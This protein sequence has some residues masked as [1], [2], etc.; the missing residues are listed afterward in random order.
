MK[1]HKYHPNQVQSI[2]ILYDNNKEWTVKNPTKHNL[3]GFSQGLLQGTELPT[4]LW[5][6]KPSVEEFAT[7]HYSVL[8]QDMAAMEV[9][10]RSGAVAFIP[11]KP[12]AHFVHGM[13]VQ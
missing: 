10:H 11:L 3:A 12:C 1:Q 4:K 8:T 13:Y 5:Y 6:T 7:L 9:R 2:K